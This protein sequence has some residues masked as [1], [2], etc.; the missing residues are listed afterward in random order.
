MTQIKEIH[1]K[2]VRNHYVLNYMATISPCG[3]DRAIKQRDKLV[4]QLIQIL[5]AEEKEEAA[6][7]ADKSEET[8]TSINSEMPEEASESK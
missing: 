3:T 2:L 5:C 4:E 7:K 1:K 8:K 6:E